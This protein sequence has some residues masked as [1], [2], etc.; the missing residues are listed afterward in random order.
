MAEMNLFT[1]QFPTERSLRTISTL[2]VE[3]N[4]RASDRHVKLERFVSY[5]RKISN[6]R[7]YLNLAFRH[8]RGDVVIECRISAVRVKAWSAIERCRLRQATLIAH[9]AF[10]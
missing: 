8:R 10:R 4:A 6:V 3:A 5:Q 2:S 9:S 1:Y 7:L